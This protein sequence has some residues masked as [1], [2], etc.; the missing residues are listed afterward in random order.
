P[1]QGLVI[2]LPVVADLYRLADVLL[3]PSHREG[4]GMPVLEAGLLGMP[5]FAATTVPAAV[6]I[7][8][9]E[10]FTFAPDLPAATLAQQIYAFAVADNRL[11][12]ARQ[13]RQ[14]MSWPAIFREQIEPLL[15]DQEIA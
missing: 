9:E 15:P 14:H 7:G 1:E 11:R 4:F 6:E 13:I 10:I 2:D 3:L 12:L 5:V 8:A